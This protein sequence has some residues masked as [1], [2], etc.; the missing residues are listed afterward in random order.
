[1]LYHFIFNKIYL[2]IFQPQESLHTLSQPPS[3]ALYLTADSPSPKSWFSCIA[4]VG[5]WRSRWAE[6]E[7][8]GILFDFAQHCTAILGKLDN[9]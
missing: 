9:I 7:R 5:V 1:M 4:A 6:R 3:R 8:E 2:Q